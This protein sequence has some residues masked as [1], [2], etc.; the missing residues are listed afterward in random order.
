MVIA[1]PVTARPSA[2]V[3]VVREGSSG[4][5]LLLVRRRA[6][7]AFGDS[8][9]FPGGVIDADETAAHAFCLGRTAA[10]ADRALD[11]PGGGLDYYSAA[12][13]ELF[14]ETG[15]L[16]AR[17]ADGIWASD[18]S[19]FDDLRYQ[20][21]K[22]LLPWPKFL[23]R[24]G[25]CMAGDALH[26]FAWWETPYSQ[27]KR[28]TTRFFLAELPPG[29]EASHD[30]SEVTDSRWLTADRALALGKQGELPMPFPTM[31]NLRD[32]SRFGSVNELID[33]A[34]RRPEDGIRKIRPALAFENGKPKFL[35]PGDPGYDEADQE[36]Q[37]A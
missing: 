17:N 18:G 2:T 3:V 25:L 14:E 4:P 22:G 27:P 28:W 6:G 11:L 30:G 32:L 1:A 29:Q 34:K 10:Q 20:V 21:D 16:L 8:Y 5:E 15:I 9:A 37:K 7:D 31:L 23:H 12:I 26:Y 33:W 24:Q 19:T 35:I 13:R 36:W